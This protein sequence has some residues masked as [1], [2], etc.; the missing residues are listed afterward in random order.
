MRFRVCA[1][2][3]LFL[4]KICFKS[5]NVLDYIYINYGGEG[6]KLIRNY[7]RLKRR[8]AKITLDLEF[9]KKCK[10]YDKF[11]KFLQFKLYRKSLQS[12]CF[13]RKWQTKLLNNEIQF[14]QRS[15]KRAEVE[16][17]E[18]EAMVR[19]LLSVIDGVIVR[20]YVD[21]MVHR[22]RNNTTIVH[23]RKLNNLGVSNDVRP[24]DPEKVVFNFSKLTLN[25]R[26]KT[27]LA[28]GLDFCLPVYKLNFYKY[29]LPLESFISRLKYL[30]LH[31]D[32]EYA[33]FLNRFHSSTMKYFYNFNP[34]K[35][36]SAVIGKS[37][38]VELRKL[39]SNREIVVCKPDKG[40]GVVLMDRSSYV[41]SLLK[42]ISDRA[43]FDIIPMSLEK[44]TQKIEDKINNFLRK[45]RELKVIS[46]DVYSQ[47]QVSGSAPGV[48][49]G[50][51][52]VHKPDFSSQFQ[53]RPIFAAYNSPSYSIAQYL[54]PILSPIAI[55]DYSVENSY[56]FVNDI[57]GLTCN[58]PNYMCSFDVNS[59]FTNIPLQETIQIILD[60]LF[61]ST[62]STFRGFSCQLFK[63]FLSL[64]VSNSFF[65]FDNKLYKQTDGLGMGLP[66]APT[67]ANI[68]MSFHEKHWLESCP[69]EFSPLFYR[70]YVDDTFVIFKQESHAALFFNFINSQHPNIKFTMEGEQN[71]NISFLDVLI[72]RKDNSYST[73]VYRKPTD[74]GLSI[75]FFSFCSRRFKLNSI[76]TFISRAYGICSSYF[77]LHREFEYLKTFFSNNGFP[78]PLID[79][80]ISKFLQTKFDPIISADQPL[81]QKMYFT[82]PYF[83]HQS[84]KLKT[85]IAALLQ[86]Y[87]PSISFQIILINKFKIGSLFSFKDKLPKAMRGS[88]VYK[89]SCI[90]C[91]SEYIG[92]TTRLLHVRVAEHAGRSF[93]TNRPLSVPPH[94]NIRHHTE[95][96]GAPISIDHFSIIDTCSNQ[97]DLR[98]LESL[99]IFK[100]KPSLNSMNSAAPLSIVTK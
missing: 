33:E 74:T 98:I 71:G 64:A 7:E 89:F 95:Q 22:Y 53:L 40:R 99:H 10:I 46:K 48:L 16:V 5:S 2:A 38:I 39:A 54:V 58:N 14:K 8:Y 30:G 26:V 19:V 77:S 21:D 79:R 72:S 68:F 51:P 1:L 87:F 43:K 78:S 37:D 28:F 42:L 47:L 67:F 92:S 34:F 73:E 15:L 88:L 29:F 41:Q 76:S 81:A 25:S 60:K 82:L 93:R 70:R 3:I 6:K 83:G 13:Y 4:I 55:N 80:Y 23:K 97:I 52:K 18:C 24:C 61:T 9:L 96:C 11:P 66:L 85:E 65:I 20:K 12:S 50:L 57:S 90:R 49:Y 45:I 31:R 27:L 69:E 36:F 56:S 86:K 94:S 84:E 17:S 63:N 91:M 32:I 35:V 100:S 75:S 62:S 44:Y 59:L